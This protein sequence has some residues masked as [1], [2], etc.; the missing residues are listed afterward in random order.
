MQANVV[1]MCITTPVTFLEV[2]DGDTI[3]VEKDGKIVGIHVDG[4]NYSGFPTPSRRQEIYS[5]TIEI[6]DKNIKVQTLVSKAINTNEIID[7]FESNEQMELFQTALLRRYGINDSNLTDV[8]NSIF[9]ALDKF[10]TD[11]FTNKDLDGILK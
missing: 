9:E 1:C 11:G 2:I 4:K 3:R 5:Q 10:E 6:V 8:E 7:N